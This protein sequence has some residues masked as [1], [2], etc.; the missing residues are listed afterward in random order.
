MVAKVT[1]EGVVIPKTL[2]G[3][4]TEVQIIEQPGRVVVVFDPSADPIWGLGKNPITL[5]VDDASI[6]HDK[7]IYGQ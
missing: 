7:Y 4:A 5:D 6:N 3:K 2:L 1:D